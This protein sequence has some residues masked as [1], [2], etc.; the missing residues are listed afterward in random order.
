MMAV[1]GRA[2][3]V[4]QPEWIVPIVTSADAVRVVAIQALRDELDDIDEQMNKL[5]KA[6][7]SF[8]HGAD[9]LAAYDALVKHRQAQCARIERLTSETKEP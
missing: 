5:L 8:V 3:R 6:R 9:F 1:P 7:G 2:P 4:G